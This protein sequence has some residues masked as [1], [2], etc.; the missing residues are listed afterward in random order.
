MKV[1]P[2]RA[3][4]ALSLIYVFLILSLGQ[5]LCW[6][7]ISPLGYHRPSIQSYQNLQFQTHVII[8]KG[9]VLRPQA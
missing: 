3:A 4:C 9:K 5:Y 2:E 1:I 6:W 8:N 7:T